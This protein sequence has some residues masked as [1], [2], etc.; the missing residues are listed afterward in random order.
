MVRRSSHSPQGARSMDSWLQPPQHRLVAGLFQPPILPDGNH[1]EHGKKEWAAVGQDVFGC[2]GD[3][4]DQGGDD[5]ATQGGSVR[6]RA[7]H[8]RRSMG[9]QRQLH[10][11]QLPEG[12]PSTDASDVHQ[13]SDAGQGGSEVSVR[14]PSVQDTR[15]GSNLYLDFQLEDAGQTFEVGP[16]W[17]CPAAA[18]MI[19]ECNAHN[20]L[21]DRWYWLNMN[22]INPIIC[23]MVS[24]N[25]F[26]L[27]FKIYWMWKRSNN[28]MTKYVVLDHCQNFAARW[29]R[30][31]SFN[32]C[33]Y[34]CKH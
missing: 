12:S 31:R 10:R 13:S 33:F 7:V 5:P 32:I 20:A 3:Q 1:A 16:G 26:W 34:V 24:N 15:A 27:V 14:V 21:D 22:R 8:G 6:A 18:N 17:G 2:W 30:N 9:H 19:I 23:V 25:T 28:E 11:G 29:G 4:E